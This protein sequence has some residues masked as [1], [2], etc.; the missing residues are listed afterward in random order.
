MFCSGSSTSSSAEVG[1]PRKSAPTLSISSIMKTG[2]LRVRPGVID[3]M[4]RPG[5]AP[6]YVRRCPRISASS[7]TPP[8]DMRMN[9][10]LSARAIDLPIEVLPTPGGPTKHR[11]GPRML[12][13]EL[14]HREVLEDALLDL[15]EAV[16]VLV[17]DLLRRDEVELLLVLARSTA[18]R[19][20]QSRYVRMTAVS[21]AACG[22][23]S[24]R[25]SSLSAFSSTSSGM[26]AVLDLLLVLVDLGLDLV[27]LAELLLDRLE[28]LAQEVLA[29]R[30]GHRL[31]DAV[32]D[33]AAELEDLELLA[34]EPGGLLEALL[35]VERL[36]DRPASPRP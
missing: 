31:L 3:W 11:I 28:L 25:P 32:L 5:S 22:I 18:A 29:L 20:S 33:L 12:V 7:R 8:S 10:R 17:E 6:T 4:M 34:Q 35:R 15:L 13:G 23:F 27:V 2:F 36:E 24:S 30:L 16:V 21:A 1:S 26:P 19:S 14:V 9:L